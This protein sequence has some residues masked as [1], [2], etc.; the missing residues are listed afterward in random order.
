M[1]SFVLNVGGL[2]F[3]KRRTASTGAGQPS[4]DISLEQAA[5]MAP[6]WGRTEA[7]RSFDADHPATMSGWP[8]RGA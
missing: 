7:R 6:Q 1:A 8:T 5:R 4:R 2:R 3:G